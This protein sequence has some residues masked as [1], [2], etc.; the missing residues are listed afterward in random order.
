M[1]M[2]R[3]LSVAATLLVG[4]WLFADTVRY[5]RG[6][7]DDDAIRFAHFG[8][9]QDYATWKRLIAAFERGHPGIQVTQEYVAGWYG[10]YDTKMRQQILAGTLPDVL[11]VSLGSF[12]QVADAFAD[13]SL[14]DGEPPSATR[15]PTG[16]FDA[17]ALD[18]FLLDGVQRAWPVSGGNLMIYCNTA[19]FDRAADFRGEPLPLPNDDWTMAD[20]RRTARALTCDFDGDGE[21]DQFGF[22]QPRW[23]YYLPFLSSFGAE[24]LDETETDWRLTGPAAEAAFQFYQD[25]KLRDRSCPRPQDMAQ[26]VQDVGFL[27]GKVGMCVNGPWFMPFLRE[28]QLWDQTYLVA[29]PRGPGG[30]ATRIT[31]DGIAVAASSAGVRGDHARQFVRFVCSQTGQEMLA[32]TQRAL[33]ARLS[34]ISA[35]LRADGGTRSAKFVE[36]LSYSRLQPQTPY[37]QE[38]DYAINRHLR[39]L[40]DEQHPITVDEFLAN[41]SQ[42]D[43]IVRRFSSPVESTP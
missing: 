15:T 17:V 27:T 29:P 6:R 12:A 23:V 33:P 37:F 43:V 32:E 39:G 35:F 11:L 19:C 28:T 1:R 24:V 14:T 4:W 5:Y 22:W 36:A 9:Y 25:L 2:R 7:P 31:W 40:L 16:E 8:T 41:L 3:V 13:L 42:D 20:F 26:I 34:A 18:A 21:T 30:R 10:L 38:M